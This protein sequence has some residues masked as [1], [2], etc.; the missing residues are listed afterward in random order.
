MVFW[1]R[2]WV[3]GF[4]LWGMQG[5]HP[6]LLRG[7]EGVRIYPSQVGIFESIIWAISPD[8]G[9]LWMDFC[10]LSAG[11][12]FIRNE[13]ANLPSVPQA[14]NCSAIEIFC[15]SCPATRMDKLRG[16]LCGAGWPLNL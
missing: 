12:K 5:G 16:I 11:W 15:K 13:N 8:D 3:G 10:P 4:S 7:V 14:K 2:F 1:E 6:R 9:R